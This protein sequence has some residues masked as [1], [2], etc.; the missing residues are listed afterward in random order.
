MAYGSTS[1]TGRGHKIYNRFIAEACCFPPIRDK[2]VLNIVDGLRAIYKSG[3][4][5]VSRYIW[6]ANTIYVATD[7]VACDLI[8]WEKVFAKQVGEG[9]GQM[10]DWKSKLEKH[11][12]LARAEKLGLGV[13]ARDKINHRRLALKPSG[14]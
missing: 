14:E 3:P 8:G 5:A 7:P 13:L 6:N 10:E 11:D 1:N 4:G 2:T 9:V 12:W